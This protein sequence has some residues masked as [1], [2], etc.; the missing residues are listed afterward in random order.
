MKKILLILIVVLCI[1]SV[2]C[3]KEPYN[4][5]NCIETL[6]D[7]GLVVT[8]SATDGQDLVMANSNI[9]L[10]IDAFKGN[11]S[12]KLLSYT[13]LKNPQNEK[14]MCKIW[15]ME[16]KEQASMYSGFYMN[17]RGENDGWK[18]TAVDNIVIATNISSVP[19]T[20]NLIFE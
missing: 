14:Q 16:T 10:E 1:C 5:K 12:V 20:L 8:E 18:V 9:F 6:V 11:F 19:K 3:T 13:V 4:V 15:E 2:S 7:S 17:N